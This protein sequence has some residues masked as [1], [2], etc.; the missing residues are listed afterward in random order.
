MNVRRRWATIVLSA[1]CLV[2]GL[3]VPAS[4]QA[5]ITSTGPLTTITTTPDL[6]CAVNHVDDTAGEFYANT[7]CGTFVAINGT[8]YG[9]ASI[10]A[11]SSLGSYTP[12]TSAGQTSG[13]GGNVNDPYRITTTVTL[14]DSG[15]VHHRRQ[16][17]LLRAFAGDGGADVA[18]GVVEEE[19]DLLGGH[20]LGGHDEVA[21]VLAVLVVDDDHHLATAD[22]GDGVG[23]RGELELRHGWCSSPRGRSDGRRAA[24][25]RT[26]R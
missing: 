25:P 4:A 18:G 11:G 12:Y 2:F 20:G 19:G 16:G 22:G 10:P 6:N 21:L 5:S 15:V 8:L 13:G 1:L 3:V 24:A 14:G 26:W 9:P 17:K 7:A 23:D